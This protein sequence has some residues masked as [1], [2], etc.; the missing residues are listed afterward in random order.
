M[1]SK[2][3]SCTLVDTE[4]CLCSNPPDKGLHGDLHPSTWREPSARVDT[5][6]AETHER[7]VEGV[8][9]LTQA[10]RE[11]IQN[12]QCCRVPPSAGDVGGTWFLHPGVVPRFVSLSSGGLRERE[13]FFGASA[14]I[15]HTE[16]RWSRTFFFKHTSCK[17]LY[18]RHIGDT[19][20]CKTRSIM[21]I[22]LTCE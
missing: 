4:P 9:D 2:T 7:K 5:H 14:D 11:S 19:L 22:F 21:S 10:R 18:G 17:C 20:S 6:R 8:D 1:D 3:Q 16:S 12:W 15:L 13:R